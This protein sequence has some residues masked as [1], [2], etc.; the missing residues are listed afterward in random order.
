M[1]KILHLLVLFVFTTIVN[2]TE[3]VIIS[4]KITNTTDGK[5]K[6]WGESFEKEIALKPD[7]TFS[8]VLNVSYSGSYTITTAQNR[9]TIYLGK[10]MKMV[11]N[12]DNKEFSK[13]LLF[14]GKGGIEN[15][16]LAD[17]SIILNSIGNEELYRMNESEFLKKIAE[18][19]SELMVNYNKS[20]FDDVAFKSNEARSLAYLEQIYIINYPKYHEHYAKAPGFKASD[21][22]PKFD[23]KINLDSEFDYLFSNAYKQLVN[24]KFNENIEKQMTNEAIPMA[25]IALPEIKKYKSQS[26]KNGFAQALSY[27]INAGN[28][29]AE[30]LYNELMAISSNEKFK[31]DLTTKYAK[32]K[33][34]LSGKLSPQ[35]DYENHKGG[36][37]SLAS[38]KGKYVYIDVWAT[39]CGP[40]RQ[41]I[42]ALQKVESQYHGKNIEFV[43]VSIDA[44]KDYDKWKAM[45]TDKQ[46]GGIQLIAD[47]DWNSQFVKDYAIDGIPRFIIV[48]PDGNIVNA[49]APR[50]SDPKLI[51]IFN[52]LKL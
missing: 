28:P 15:Q 18:I 20:K 50:P 12:A 32:I 16:Y 29:D 42:P 22:F 4:G 27:E 9:A 45:V 47:S 30:N 7:G 35:F 5:L 26:I 37:T 46:L 24:A 23:S 2:A 1:K 36:K 49:D 39:W 11:V 10:G 21:K 52:N 3:T 43:S 8:E 44:R 14:S 33:T 34:L 6:I 31:S 48:G 51:N 40:C 25:T 19:K 41:E 17:K 38:L 13:T